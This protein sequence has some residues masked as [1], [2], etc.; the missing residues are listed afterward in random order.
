MKLK[1]ALSSA[2][3][4]ALVSTPAA[5]NPVSDFL[6]TIFGQQDPPISRGPAGHSRSHAEGLGS[7]NMIASFYGGGEYLNR[8]TASGE[9]FRAN[10]LT[11]AHRTLPFGTRLSVCYRSCVVVRINDRGPAASTGRSLDLSRA[12]ARAIGMPGVGRVSATVL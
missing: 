10:D 6:E 9:V 4:L 11:A 1:H 5:A 3:S 8:R 7:G 12:A 2:L